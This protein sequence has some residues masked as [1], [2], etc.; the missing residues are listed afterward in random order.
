VVAGVLAVAVAASW[1]VS[2]KGEELSPVVDDP[3][4]PPPGRD[5][6]AIDREGTAP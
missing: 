1:V 2:E 4:D 6:E 3:R 5:S